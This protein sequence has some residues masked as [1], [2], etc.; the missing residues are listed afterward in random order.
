MVLRGL[1]LSIFYKLIEMPGYWL[2]RRLLLIKLNKHFC[3]DLFINNVI[4]CTV[5]RWV[6]LDSLVVS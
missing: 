4:Y 3:Y 5:L 1:R 6:T 2:D